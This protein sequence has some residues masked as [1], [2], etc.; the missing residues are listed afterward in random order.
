MTHPRE[1]MPV[2]QLRFNFDAVEHHN[3]VWSESKPEFSIFRIALGVDVPH[4]ERF[5]VKVMRAYRDELDDAKLKKDVQ[6]II[7]QEAHH[8]FNFINWTST[9]GTISN[10]PFRKRVKNS[11]LDSQ[12]AMKHL[13]F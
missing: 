2:R 6:A 5:L 11:R 3:P 8:A 13:L 12:R 4:F 1:Q 7:G 9:P 10:S